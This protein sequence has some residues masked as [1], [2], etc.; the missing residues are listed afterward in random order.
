MDA[1]EF[2]AFPHAERMAWRAVKNA[3]T[4]LGEAAKAV[5]NDVWERHPEVDWR[6]FGRLRDIVVHQYFRLDMEQV[7]KTIKLEIP[8]ILAVAKTELGLL[9]ADP[10]NGS[11]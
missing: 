2:K 9:D 8:G 1:E 7:R 5:P 10:S 3:L 6:G 11:E 4:E